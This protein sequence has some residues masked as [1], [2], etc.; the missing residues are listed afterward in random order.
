MFLIIE[1][2]LTIWAFNRG[3]RWLALLPLGLMGGLGFLIGIIIGVSGGTADDAQ[4]V[5]VLDIIAV[6]AL[7]WMIAK[8]KVEKPIIESDIS[9][10]F[11][12]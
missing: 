6:I 5:I 11:T 8:P 4:W 7:I 3:W 2:A 12:K 9:K 10:D 1:I